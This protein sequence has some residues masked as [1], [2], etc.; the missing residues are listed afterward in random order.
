MKI[1]YNALSVLFL[2]AAALLVTAP[3]AFAQNLIPEGMDPETA[4]KYEEFITGEISRL[5][6]TLKLDLRQTFYVDSIL[7]HDY[8]SMQTELDA[9]R[10]SKVS[11]VDFYTAVKDKWYEQIYQSLRKVFNDEQWEKYL[12]GGAERERKA[13]EKRK[14]RIEKAG[15]K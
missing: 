7:H 2:C 14:A 5:E 13:R 9:L 1:I 8:F 4:K 15:K 10:A 3:S 6:T 11:N 12:K